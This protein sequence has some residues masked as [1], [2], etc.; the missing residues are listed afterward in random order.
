MSAMKMPEAQAPPLRNSWKYLADERLPRLD[1]ATTFREVYSQ[2]NRSGCSGFIL[3][4]KGE[5]EGY[6]KAS[7]LAEQVVQ[8]ANGDAQT[9]RT[10]SNEPIGK[11]VSEFKTM[12]VP[13]Q[14]A[15]TDATESVLQNTGDTVFRI[16]ETDG[17]AGWYLNHEGVLATATKKTVFI[18][19]NGHRNPDPDHGTCYRCPFPIIRTDTE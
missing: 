19:T 10:Y 8:K 4:A 3:S 12:L 13:V 18:C 9:L 17:T 7:E 14:L 6:V 5:V 11:I 1:T 15:A 16:F 2:L